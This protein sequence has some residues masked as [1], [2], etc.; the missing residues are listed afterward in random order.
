[1]GRDPSPSL[2]EL[3]S[4]LHK[5]EGLAQ[6][7][8]GNLG[9]DTDELNQ[10]LHTLYNVKK[11]PAMPL[12]CSNK[13]LADANSS[14]KTA[15]LTASGPALDA[16]V[17]QLKQYI[18]DDTNDITICAAGSSL[19]TLLRNS[20]RP[21]FVVY[22]EMGSNVFEDITELLTDGFDL[23]EITLVC[24]TTIDPRVPSLFTKSI[25]YTRPHSASVLL[26]A[27]FN[28]SSLIHSGP[29][30]ANAALDFLLA[31][32]FTN[33]LALGCQFCA[34]RRSE[35]RSLKAIGKND[36]DLSLPVLSNRGKTVFTDLG[37]IDCA[38]YFDHSVNLYRASVYQI[39]HSILQNSIPIESDSVFQELVRSSL[40]AQSSFADIFQTPTLTRS[41]T[42]TL[43]SALQEYLQAWRSLI[44][45]NNKWSYKLGVD[46]SALLN[47]GPSDNPKS[48][49]SQSFLPLHIRILRYA[50][51]LLSRHLYTSDPI[52]YT[53]SSSFF[54]SKLDFI[55]SF[56]SL[57]YDCIEE[58]I[59]SGSAPWSD[60]LILNYIDMLEI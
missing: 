47:S 51:F 32:G 35:T 29:Q 54:L 8:Y 21:Q 58:S 45:S 37:L 27:E 30:A 20:L 31:I 36:R 34:E 28:H 1:M 23:S 26:K 11:Y 59:Y 38:K 40:N 57:Y 2:V 53:A 19:G 43:M 33:I 16:E 50:L 5:P 6:I 17:D 44:S 12:L 3:R 7:L 55:E 39:S 18:C 24:P 49:T 4:W 52:K 10:V 13:L 9:N 46:I 14:P 56:F 25:F 22:N 15:I 48:G 41:N 60:K 42:Q